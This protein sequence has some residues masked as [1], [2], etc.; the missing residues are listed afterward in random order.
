VGLAEIPARLRMPVACTTAF[1]DW[2]ARHEYQ[3]LCETGRRLYWLDSY[4]ARSGALPASRNLRAE[5]ASWS[6][7]P[8]GWWQGVN[9]AARTALALQE[10]RR[11]ATGRCSSADSSLCY[12]PKLEA[13]RRRH[14]WHP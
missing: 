1:G 13:A 4:A 5:A 10:M 14:I 12:T 7:Q 8:T 2:D 11:T 9:D 3:A 6:R